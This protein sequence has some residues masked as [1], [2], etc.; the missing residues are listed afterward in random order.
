M[1]E[2]MEQALI[3]GI[4][5]GQGSRWIAQQM[6]NA[7]NIPEERALLIARTEVNRAYR[8]ANWE[9]QRDSR[10]VIGYRRMCYKPT[11]CFACLMLDGEFYPKTQ[12]PTDHPNGKCSFVP[13]S[14]HFDP[15]NMEGWQKGSDWLMEQDEETQRRIMGAGC[16]DLWKNYGVDPK[17]MVYIKPNPIWGGSPAMRPLSKLITGYQGGNQL[18]DFPSAAGMNFQTKQNMQISGI[19]IVKS[20]GVRG[21]PNGKGGYLRTENCDIYTT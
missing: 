18:I 1:K 15:A 2:G 13:V 5:T 21:M 17:N 4:S 8:Q 16:F 6:M 11:A 9:R 3:T 12:E 14:K 7:A 10:A 20:E 19:E